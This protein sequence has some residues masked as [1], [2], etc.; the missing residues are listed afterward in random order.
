MS[1]HPLTTEGS[2][3]EVLKLRERHKD[4]QSLKA[5]ETLDKL[6]NLIKET[7][8]LE[9]LWDKDQIYHFIVRGP[10]RLC[11]I[12][13]SGSTRGIVYLQIL[14]SKG[15][16]DKRNEEKAFTTTELLPYLKSRLEE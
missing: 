12:F 15:T 4:A 6:A 9:I 8:P 11:S 16:V 5:F 13:F 14:T 3:E 10:K 1:I 2:K 7:T